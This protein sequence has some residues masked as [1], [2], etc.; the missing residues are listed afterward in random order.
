LF[1][2]EKSIA[3]WRRQMLAAGIKTPVPLEELESHL[4]EEIERQI[5]LGFDGQEA[6]E[7][8]AQRIGRPESLKNEFKI[9]ERNIMKRIAMIALG[10]FGILF[11]PGLILPALAKHKDL[12]I[13]NYDIVWPIVLGALITLVGV[14][15]TIVGF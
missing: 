7:I 11:G 3:D 6:F 13:W 14:S 4:R 12:G 1:D 5:K 15:T 8:S 9:V 2:L 10:I